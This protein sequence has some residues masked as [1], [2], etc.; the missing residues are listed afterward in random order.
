MGQEEFNADPQHLRAEAEKEPRR[1]SL[2]DYGDT[3]R[4]LKEEKGFSF[5]EIAGWFHQRGVSIDHNAAWRAYSKTTPNSPGGGVT[6]QNER[7]EHRTPR[8]G[9]MPWLKESQ[10]LHLQRLSR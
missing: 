8:E 2:G 6:E 3:I 7:I 1:R 10:P 4:L 5:R 9:A